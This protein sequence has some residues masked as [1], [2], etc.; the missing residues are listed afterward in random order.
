MVAQQ[1]PLPSSAFPCPPKQSKASQEIAEKERKNSSRRGSG[2]EAA[3][4]AEAC[5]GGYLSL[6]LSSLL[7]LGLG[8]GGLGGGNM[9][10][11]AE[12]RAEGFFCLFS[13]EGWEYY[14]LEVRRVRV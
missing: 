13:D 6:Y 12:T 14:S 11:R 3:A 7:G 1:H 9:T 8:L 5:T 4:A 2:R 10:V